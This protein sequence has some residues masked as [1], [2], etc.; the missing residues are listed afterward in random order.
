MRPLDPRL[1][2]YA[3]SIRVFLA[4][5]TLI[6]LV[7]TA[8]VIG[9]AAVLTRIVTGALDGDSLS[10]LGPWLGALVGV[11]A[12]RALTVWA[13]ETLSMRAAG[14]VK[15]ELRGK[16]LDATRKLGPSWLARRGSISV[17]TLSGRGMDALDDYFAKYLPQLILTALVTP[18][19]VVVIWWQ[20]WV[21]GIVVVVTLPLI[22]FF[23][24]LVGWATQSI[25]RNQWDTLGKLSRGFVDLLGG[26]ATLKIFGRQHRQADRMRTI[27][28]DYRRATMKVLRVTFLSGF[29]LELA[30]SLA[31]AIVA[32]GIGLR[33][34]EGNMVLSVGLFVLL[35]AP[36]VFLPLRNVGTNFHAAAEGVT[37]SEDA[38]EIL[39]AAAVLPEGAARAVLASADSATPGI[40]FVEV[41]A[42]H[43]A[44]A[45]LAHAPLTATVAPG[46]LTVLSG[47]SGVGKS[48]LVGALLG[49][50]DY[51]GEITRDGASLRGV[52]AG[53]RDWLA[54]SPQR[55]G[56]TAGTIAENVTLGDDVP[57]PETLAWAL[58]TAAATDLDPARDL[59]VAGAGLSGGQAQ[60]VGIARALYRQRRRNCA[61]LI[62]DEPSSALDHATE[63]VLVQN[64]RALAA[65][66]V[67]VLVL[68]HRQAFL[69]GAD[70]RISLTPVS[71]SA[72]ETIEVD[73]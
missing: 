15:A 28:A 44:D 25:Q 64:L 67:S 60:R 52:P 53:E 47:P 57:D 8:C 22:P 50:T 69:S 23:M 27:T 9:F 1:L 16:I 24:A 42:Q 68:S 18:I 58:E 35:L 7:T 12:V 54:W 71:V 32:V 40:A 34:V 17:A 45:P 49:F 11:A 63:D 6:G 41:R 48:S 26:L 13:S 66:G 56:L 73:A 29:V 72:A 21:S 31:V 2:R 33:L 10:V 30:S 37:A 61:V 36:E 43:E 4:A 51:V 39:D 55:P 14:R 65:T 19:L 20:D 5:Q 38:F 70:A 59:G 3:R 62:L 46:T